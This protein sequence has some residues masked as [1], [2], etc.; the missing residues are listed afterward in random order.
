MNLECKYQG[1]VATTD[2]IEFIRELIAENPNDS[3]RALSQKLCR[4]WNWVQPNGALREMVC[5][6]FLLRLES[7][8]Y[9]KLPP[10]RCIPNNPLAN[11]KTPPRVDIDQTLLQT[12]LS[13]IQPLE[14]RQVR[15]H[16]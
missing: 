8:G 13:K 7:A 3:R 1:R 15:H 2:D 9:I 12:V 4:A 16:M 10:R 14:I 11:R 6:G 5:R